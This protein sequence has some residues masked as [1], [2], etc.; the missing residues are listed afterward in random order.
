MMIQ[1][2]CAEK[3][4]VARKMKRKYKLVEKEGELYAVP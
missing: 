4:Y 2:K 1:I 3:S